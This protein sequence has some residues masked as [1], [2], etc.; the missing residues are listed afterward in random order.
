M[1]TA[2]CPLRIS[3]VGGSTDLQSFIDEYGFGKVI[4]FPTTLYTYINMS[5]RHD[6]LYRINYS[7]TEEIKSP[8]EIK[9]DIA[10]EVIKY[11]KIGP[12]TMSFNSDI[13][14]TGSGLASSSSYTVAAVAAA[15]EY[16][17]IKTSQFEICKIAHQIELIF[18]P[19]TGYQDCYGCG[20]PSAKL[21]EFYGGGDVKT[22]ITHVKLP[23]VNMLLYPTDALR[24]S[25]NVL[26][27][28]NIHK[29]H[30]LLDMVD[31]CYTSLDI[32]ELDMFKEYLDKAWQTKKLTSKN[33][34]NE[35][36]DKLEEQLRFWYDVFMIKLCGAGGGGYFFV[37]T[38]DKPIGKSIEVKVDNKGVQVWRV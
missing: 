37:M 18:N 9:N 34:M 30:E 19:L 17:G 4:S 12:I 21:L 1:I 2:K 5:K 27:T 8:N 32:G 33:I 31:A 3:L 14:S 24:S 16:Q 10:R 35:K 29:S 26:K 13:N 23:E 22:K 11:F 38:Q 15:M 25:T 36:L 28:I 7:M 20:L 6:G